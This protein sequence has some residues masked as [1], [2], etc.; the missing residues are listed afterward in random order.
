MRYEKP[1]G[2]DEIELARIEIEQERKY[3]VMNTPVGK[4]AP[5]DFIYSVPDRT[6]HNVNPSNAQSEEEDTPF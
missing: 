4:W 5:A 3:Q 1:E 6:I 2:W